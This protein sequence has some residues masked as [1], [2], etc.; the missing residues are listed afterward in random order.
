M[1]IHKPTTNREE[2][3][4]F[5]SYIQ[6]HKAVSRDTISRWGK[7]ALDCSGVNTSIFQLHSTRAAASS[8][9][10]QK[11]VALDEILDK[12]GWKSASTFGKFYDKP[13][14]EDND[15]A[16]AALSMDSLLHS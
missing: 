10:K 9:A 5:L 8:K 2:R 16:A 15:I 14:M 7:Q 1:L 11:E 3:Q 13:I 6:P 12:V 4:L